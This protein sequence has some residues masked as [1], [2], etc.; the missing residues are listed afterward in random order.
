[1]SDPDNIEE[2]I[3]NENSGDCVEDQVAMAYWFYDNDVTA[4]EERVNPTAEIIAGLEEDLS[5]A[6]ETVIGNLVDIEVLQ[7][8]PVSGSGTYIRNHRTETNF[9]TP[10]E[11]GFVASI[12]EEITRLLLDVREQERAAQAAVADGGPNEENPTLREVAAEA[13]D[14][15]PDELVEALTG[16]VHFIDELPRSDVE[17]EVQLNDAVKRMNLYDSAVK[18]IEDNDGVEKRREYG[19]MGWRNVANRYTLTQTATAIENNHSVTD[20]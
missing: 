3:R 9:Y 1:M 13:V 15:S 8:V 17:E 18:A 2:L 4:Q 7:R 5:H 12:T 19:P 14:V 6:P 16:T 11:D 10:S 20:F